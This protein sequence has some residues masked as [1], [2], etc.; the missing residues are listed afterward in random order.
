M[1]EDIQLRKAISYCIENY[2]NEEATNRI[3]EFIKDDRALL[4]LINLNRF[5]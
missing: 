4:K 3:M 1:K 2:S 5:K